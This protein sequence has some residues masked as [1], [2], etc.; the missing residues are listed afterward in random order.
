M[1]NS[2]TL[3][4]LASKNFS[5]LRDENDEPIDT[6]TDPF[7]RNFARNSVKGCRCNAFYQL[8]KSEISDEIFNIIS[9]ELNVNRNMCNLLEKNFEFSNKY[10]KLY[11][12]ELDSKYEDY[13][14]LNQEEKSV[15]IN[16]K[17]NMLPIHKDLSK[18][19]LN[20]TQIDFDATSLY[21]SGMW[22]Q[23]SVYRK[24]E[25]GLCFKRDMNDVYVEA[26]KNQTL[27]QD[28]NESVI[29][30]I[31]YYNPPD[32]IIQHLPDK[33]KV[34][35]IEVSRMRNGYIIDTLTSVDI[36]EI[37]K[38]GGKVTEIYEGVTSRENFEIFPFGKIIEELF[39][40]R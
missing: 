22:D 33:E 34:K 21:P 10:E 37:V 11:A 32:L 13:R 30:K 23:N 26:F 35:N 20:K 28:G 17:R 19:E 38:I 24:I 29:L 16:K 18:L 25:S 7:M 15:C 1:K 31:K 14:D 12:K 6:Y 5:N 40:S 4:S 39:A 36:C 9:R 8:Y 2:L 3:P 27:N